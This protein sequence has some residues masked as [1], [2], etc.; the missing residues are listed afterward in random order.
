MVVVVVVAGVEVVVVESLLL[1]Q[2]WSMPARAP[3]PSARIPNTR[4]EVG[5][6][7]GTISQLLG[8]Y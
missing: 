1:P 7:W 2:P 3:K 5:G 4:Y 6:Y 8:D